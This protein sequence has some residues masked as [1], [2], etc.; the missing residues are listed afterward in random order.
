MSTF[1]QGFRQEPVLERTLSSIR[2]MLLI[3]VLACAAARAAT[4]F[5]LRPAGSRNLQGPW[6]W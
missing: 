6:T 5:E 3:L 4:A 1:Q 2:S